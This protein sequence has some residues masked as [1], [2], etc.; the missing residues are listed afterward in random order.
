[1]FRRTVLSS[2]FISSVTTP[3]RLISPQAVFLSI[4]NSL[5]YNNVDWFLAN[6][7]LLRKT[8]HRSGS[9]FSSPSLFLLGILPCSILALKIWLCA[10]SVPQ[11]IVNCSCTMAKLHNKKRLFC[12]CSVSFL[13]FKF[14]VTS[15]RSNRRQDSACLFGNSNSLLHSFPYLCERISF[16][17]FSLKFDFHFFNNFFY[18]FMTS[19]LNLNCRLIYH[20]TGCSGFHSLFNEDPLHQGFIYWL[21]DVFYLETQQARCA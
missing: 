20:A 9:S 2:W 21:I 4:N 17:Q 13:N 3:P 8:L 16:A 7:L 10:C 18:Q 6:C 19:R 12:I 1:M 14:R 15:R 11:I 5:I